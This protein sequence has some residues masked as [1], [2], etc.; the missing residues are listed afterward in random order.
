MRSL[1][2]DD[3]ICQIVTLQRKI[4]IDVINRH[5]LSF[6]SA[7]L[8]IDL[9][10][11]NKLQTCLASMNHYEREKSEVL[12]INFDLTNDDFYRQE[13]TIDY[14]SLSLLI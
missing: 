10:R 7:Y 14:E 9:F 3:E 6:V 12:T 11:L 5:Q 4:C 8:S 13:S 2:V 1:I